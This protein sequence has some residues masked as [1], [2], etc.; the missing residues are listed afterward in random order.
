MKNKLE[1]IESTYQIK[2]ISINEI[3]PNKF[4]HVFIDIVDGSR[5]I[6][7]PDTMSG[8][9]FARWKKGPGGILYKDI[10]RFLNGKESG[11]YIMVEEN[12]S[13]YI[14]RLIEDEELE[15]FKSLKLISGKI[16]DKSVMKLIDLSEIGKKDSKSGYIEENNQIDVILTENTMSIK[17]NHIPQENDEDHFSQNLSLFED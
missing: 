17:P 6:N 12:Q 11:K 13:K 3:V 1:T 15:I 9:G 8:E 16:K 4:D 5:Q 10:H 2:D 14:L 7:I